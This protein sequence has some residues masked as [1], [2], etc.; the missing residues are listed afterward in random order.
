MEKGE[1]GSLYIPFQIPIQMADYDL[2]V[3]YLEKLDETCV[4]FTHTHLNYEVYYILEG[5]MRMRIGGQEHLL[6]PNHFILIPPGV[7]HGAVYNPDEPKVYV[8]FVFGI[9]QNSDSVLR[10][11][12]PEH[13]FVSLFEI[14]L[15]EQL[16]VLAEDKNSCRD[17]LFLLEQEYAEKQVGWQLLLADYCREYFVKL[18]RN[19]LAGPSGNSEDSGQANL[20]I[21]ITKYMHRHYQESITLEDVSR[22]FH[23]TPRHV[24]RIFSDYFGTSFRKTLSIYRLNYAKNYLVST[25]KPV[26]EIAALVGISAPQTLYRLFKENEGM[27]ISE[28]RQYHKRK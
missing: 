20:A 13:E 17:I 18:L 21:E 5:R 6:L 14:A 23:I 27:T 19:I 28:Y 24:T 7:S 9:H 22:A 8:V 2:S 12:S 1:K 16:Y 10:R 26:E 3:R 25:N 4:E 11:R 15:K